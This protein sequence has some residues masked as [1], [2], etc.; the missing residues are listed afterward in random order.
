MKNCI[1]VITILLNLQLLIGQKGLHCSINFAFDTMMI[2]QPMCFNYLIESNFSKSLSVYY[3]PQGS[4]WNKLGRDESFEI[5]IYSPSGKIIEKISSPRNEMIAYSRRVGFK[6]ISK[7]SNLEYKLWMDEWSNIEIPG[8]YTINAS[9]E[10]Q[11]G[12]KSGK[13]KNERLSC[14]HTFEVINHDSTK[15]TS[16]IESLW[17][18]YSNAKSYKDKEFALDILCRINSTEA[19]KYYEEIITK[20]K[21][22]F[23]IKNALS[24]ISR[25][26]EDERSLKAFK[27]IF[28][29]N[30]QIFNEGVTNPLLIDAIPNTL[31]HTTIHLVSSFSDIKAIPFLLSCKNDSYYP[32]RLFVMQELFRRNKEIAYQVISD[33]LFDENESVKSEAK[34]LLNQIDFSKKN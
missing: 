6:E 34:L 28:E 14:N 2:G 3:D 22:V 25:F 18:K 10:I 12:T 7:N 32:I 20:S 4:I 19:I 33:N 17:F 26:Q 27:F 16:I 31:K 21:N 29:L 23:N 9:K 11:I 1:V 24:G 5:M 30:P 8:T 15:L 13:I